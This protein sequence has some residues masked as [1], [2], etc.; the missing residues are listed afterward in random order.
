MS[1]IVVAGLTKTFG[2][3]RAVHNLSF[4]VEPGTISGF[5]GPNGAGKTTT[6]RCLLGLVTPTTG[7]A[8]IGG[9]RYADL[10]HPSSTVGAVLE[11]SSFH[12]ARSARNHLRVLCT[13]NGYPAARADEVLALVGLTPVANRAVRGFSTGMRQRLGLAAALLGDPGVLVLDEPANGL[14]PEGI[15]WLRAFL[16]RLA[17]EGR[18]ILISSHV[19]SEVEQTVDDIVVIDKGT[20]VRQGSLAELAR[21]QGSTVVVRAPDLD[22][23]ATA[24]GEL[25]PDL[26]RR[27]GA[28]IV[29]GLQPAQIGHLA[30]REGIELHELAAERSDLEDIFFALTGEHDDQIAQS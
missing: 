25:G 21:Q 10:P 15:A 8:T 26:Q 23:L 11:S 22:R 27:D 19:L 28:L 20:L 3:V 12:P 18:T 7:T 24:L 13:V 29:K 1:A 4:T 9:V 17:S 14:D 5:L 2:P 6:L 16:R 30:F